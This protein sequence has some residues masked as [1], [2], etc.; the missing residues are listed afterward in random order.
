MWSYA[1]GG[2]P[3]HLHRAGQSGIATAVVLGCGRRRPMAHSTTMRKLLR[4]LLDRMMTREARH[5]LIEIPRDQTGA[6]RA[7]E[8][9]VERFPAGDPAAA[10][11][12]VRNALELDLANGDAHL[13]LG[14][15]LSARNAMDEASRCFEQAAYFSVRPGSTLA[16]IG[17]LLIAKGAPAKGLVY[18]QRALDVDPF[19]IDA[20]CDAALVHIER[21]DWVQ[22]QNFLEQALRFDSEHPRAKAAMNT[23]RAR[24]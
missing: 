9:A 1:V 11:T 16:E 4:R 10:E 6:I 24:R 5:C 2:A 22:A 18:L 14:R 13:F 19:L 20:A 15:L 8:G 21:C 7:V 3:R 12:L 17:Q 23:V